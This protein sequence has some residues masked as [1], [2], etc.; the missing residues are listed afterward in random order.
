MIV[1]TR[2]FL[3]S[4]HNSLL[5]IWAK[6]RCHDR[7][8]ENA[9]ASARAPLARR[10]CRPTVRLPV[11]TSCPTALPTACPTASPIACLSDL[12]TARLPGI[13]AALPLP[14]LSA[15]FPPNSLS[16]ASSFANR[17][18]SWNVSV[19]TGTHVRYN[20]GK[21]GDRD[22]SNQQIVE[23]FF[24]RRWPDGFRC[25]FCAFPEFYLISTRSLPLYECRR[26]R[27]QT[28]VTSGTIMHKT[29]TPLAK[30]AAAVE[31]LSSSSGLNA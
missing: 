17:P 4:H 15:P 30:W 6:R 28:S 22:M 12:P 3:P 20:L 23:V 14:P 29:R 24:R 21:G 11:P 1:G 25:P 13:L 16:S 19:D 8:R 18:N 10:R 7:K 31:A 9:L 26:C 5:C 27:R 2:W